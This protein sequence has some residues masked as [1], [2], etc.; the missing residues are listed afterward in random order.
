MF[1]KEE[2]PH[3]NRLWDPE[4]TETTGNMLISEYYILFSEDKGRQNHFFLSH[5]TLILFGQSIY[6]IAHEQDT[7]CY[8]LSSFH[9]HG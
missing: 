2:K 4:Q 3:K 8:F 9:W 1:F 7:L 6:E 5:L